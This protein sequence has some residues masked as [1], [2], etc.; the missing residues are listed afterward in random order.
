M[1]RLLII[2]LLAACTVAAD[3]EPRWCL[4]TGKRDSDKLLYPPIAKAARVQGVVLSRVIYT[5]SGEVKGFEAV[6]GAPMLSKYLA[7]EI[8]KWNLESDAKGDEL[9]ETLI[10]ARFRLKEPFSCDPAPDSPTGYDFSTP[11]ILQMNLDGNAFLICDPAVTVT[12]PAG[13]TRAFFYK[14]KRGFLRLF[15]GREPVVPLL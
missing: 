13:P 7:Q 8:S 15:R 11:G 9:C 1:L 5:P 14:L 2:S 12:N 6:F 4:I 3:A 10:I